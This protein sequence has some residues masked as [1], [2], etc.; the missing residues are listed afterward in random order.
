MGIKKAEF[1][2]MSNDVSKIIKFHEEN[3]KGKVIHKMAG[4]FTETDTFY[5]MEYPSGERGNM[6]ESS[7]FDKPTYAVRF[8]VDNLDETLS[9]YLKSGFKV[10]NGPNE[11]PSVKAAVV[12]SPNENIVILMEHLKH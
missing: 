7:K 11:N 4:L 1:I 9:A 5:V 2:F 3:F 12:M 6:Y 10:V 8:N